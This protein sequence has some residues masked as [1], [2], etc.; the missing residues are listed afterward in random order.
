MI[1]YLRAKEQ[2]DYENDSYWL[3]A[4]QFLEEHGA[5]L[6]FFP[7]TQQTSSTKIK[8]LINKEIE[9]ND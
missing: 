8:A 2:C 1:Q 3:K 9:K 7:Y 5:E 6:V 4:K